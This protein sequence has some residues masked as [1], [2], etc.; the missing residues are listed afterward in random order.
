[1]R[2][3]LAFAFL[4][5]PLLRTTDAQGVMPTGVVQGGRPLAPNG[6]RPGALFSVDAST[7]SE[8]NVRFFGPIVAGDRYN[9]A[10]ANLTLGAAN[11][12]TRLEFDA[13]GEV[14]RFDLLRDLDRE[15]YNFGVLFNH[16]LSPRVV[17]QLAVRAL[18]SAAP[19]AVQSLTLAFQ[20]LAVVR[21]QTAVAS[22]V[23]RLT[24]TVDLTTD[25]EFVRSRFDD[26]TF[27]GGD[28]GSVRLS[29]GAR[30]N[31]RTVRGFVTDIRRATFLDQVVHTAMLE[32]EWRRRVGRAQLAM[33]A[34]ATTLL[35]STRTEPTTVI[36]TGSFELKRARDPYTLALGYAHAVTPVF[37]FGRALESD[38]VSLIMARTRDR[39]TSLRVTVDGSRN[40]DPVNRAININ[41]ATAEG[42]IRQYLGGGLTL[43]ITGFA[44][45]RIDAERATN[46]GGSVLLALGGGR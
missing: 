7:H 18:T 26:P 46:T 4:L 35:P 8:S 21:S 31:S 12:R 44:R 14:V 16:R 34:G 45:R 40:I 37:G 25:V 43:A 11:A 2:A 19:D 24:P 13:H 23:V 36:P 1:V 17:T 10:G 41:F 33:R 39:G 3:R 9:R 42:Q 6:P 29:L 38:Q 15:T 28:N 27:I 22:T 5:A 30:P 32:G 20:P